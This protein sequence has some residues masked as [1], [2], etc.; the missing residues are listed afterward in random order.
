MMCAKSIPKSGIELIHQA[1]GFSTSQKRNEE[2][3]PDFTLNYV[4]RSER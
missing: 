1:L 4:R 3:T 2:V